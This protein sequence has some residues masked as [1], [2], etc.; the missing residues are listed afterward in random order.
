MGCTGVT[1]RAMRGPSDRATEPLGEAPR[2]LVPGGLRAMPGGR[3]PAQLAVGGLARGGSGVVGQRRG[4]RAAADQLTSWQWGPRP[5]AGPGRGR[6]GVWGKG[7]GGLAAWRCW[8]G[9]SRPKAGNVYL[10]CMRPTYLPTHTH[11][12]YIYLHRCTG[13]CGRFL[14]DHAGRIYLYIGI[15]YISPSLLPGYSP[16]RP[17]KQDTLDRGQTAG[18]MLMP[19]Q[20]SDCQENRRKEWPTCHRKIHVHGPH[21]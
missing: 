7:W 1:A 19:A 4:R 16:P 21:P 14:R 13:S 18:L 17:W 20:V 12:Y 10:K 6:G 5:W 2:R 3:L 11:I 9:G 8:N 15:L